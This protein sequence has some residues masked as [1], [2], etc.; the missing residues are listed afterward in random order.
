MDDRELKEF[1]KKLEG[2]SSEIYDDTKGNP[3][4]GYGS[5]L[6]SPEIPE[7]LEKR[8]IKVSPAGQV[9]PAEA[10]SIFEDQLN[11]K[12]RYFNEIKKRDFP[13][14]QPTPNKERALLSAGYNSPKIWGPNLRQHLDKNDD[15]SVVKELLLK[16][17]RDKSPG[18]QKRRLE[19]AMEY[20][21]ED[22]ENIFNSLSE[23]EKRELIAPIFNIQNVHERQRVFE[24]FP[25]LKPRNRYK[26][27]R[28][29][30]E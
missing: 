13:N 4:I 11:E 20:A 25:F 9:S 12:I 23:E 28:G 7:I 19:E 16:S 10:E 17:N 5:N 26:R 14:F 1:I 15:V 22:F 27:L 18:I 21:G 2:F 8:N 3:T 6:N 29:K 24:E 30:L